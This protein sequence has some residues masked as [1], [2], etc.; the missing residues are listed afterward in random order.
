MR[1]NT[2]IWFGHVKR[3]RGNAPMR[4]YETISLSRCRRGRGQSKT[5]WNDLIR[6][7]LKFIGLM[8]DMD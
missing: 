5:S 7:D 6:K 1:E 2:L 8:E 3:R 4:S